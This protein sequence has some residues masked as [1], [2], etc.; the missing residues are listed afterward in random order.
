MLRYDRELGPGLFAFCT[1]FGQET[2][3]V[4]SYNPG[5]RAECLLWD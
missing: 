5:A 3:R 2:D 1:T 4:H